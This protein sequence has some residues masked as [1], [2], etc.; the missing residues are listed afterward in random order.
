MCTCSACS[1]KYALDVTCVELGQLDIP[2][3][4][5]HRPVTAAA[6]AESADYKVHTEV[7]KSKKQRPLA[8]GLR[9]K[10]TGGVV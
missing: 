9:L 4:I 10:Q 1:I 6:M 5:S 8:Q 7:H 3:C 2:Q